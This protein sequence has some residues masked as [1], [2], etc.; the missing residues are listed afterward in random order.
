VTPNWDPKHPELRHEVWYQQVLDTA[1]DAMVV[2][3]QD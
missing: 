3:G 2:V 1:P